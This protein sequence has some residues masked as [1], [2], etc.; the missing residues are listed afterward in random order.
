MI[1]FFDI[2]CYDMSNMI[3]LQYIPGSVC[4]LSSRNNSLYDRVA[5]SDLH[6]GLIRI[7]GDDQE[8]CLHEL[9]IHSH[10]VR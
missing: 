2:T 6:S 7:Y 3:T 4:W 10:P 9:S 8:E 1:K 5:V